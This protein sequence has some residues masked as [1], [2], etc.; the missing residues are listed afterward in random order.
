MWKPTEKDRYQFAENATPSTCAQTTNVCSRKL[1]C[2]KC[3]GKDYS[4][5]A[6]N[7]LPAFFPSSLVTEWS[8]LEA[9][10]LTACLLLYYVFVFTVSKT[11]LK[12]QM[13]TDSQPK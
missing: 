11:N 5:D 12:F 6:I 9:T 10:N 3:T 7:I 13:S 1:F 2:R 4:H 8:V